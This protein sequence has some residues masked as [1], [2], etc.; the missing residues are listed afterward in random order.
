M[1]G[2]IYLVTNTENGKRYIGKKYGNF[3]ANYLGSGVII[4]Q[5]IKKYGKEKFTVEI[6][7][8]CHNEDDLNISEIKIIEANCPEYNI[9]KGG[10]G[11]DTLKYATEE[12]KQKVIEKRSQGLKKSWENSDRTERGRAISDAKK[13]KRFGGVKSHTE[14]SKAKIRESNRISAKNRPATWRE[15]LLRAAEKRKGISNTKCNKPLVIDG[16][17]YKSRKDAAEHLNVQ[18]SAI[19]Y[20]IK[21]GRGYYL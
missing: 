10:S 14:E 6:L 15:N 13:G 9:A 2:Y 1:Y 11:G 17:E 7:K 21:K 8:E 12:M 20:Y 18:P 4:K 3:D 19:N 16:T 5:A